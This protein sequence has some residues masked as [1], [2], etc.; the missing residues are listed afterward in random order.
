MVEA[1]KNAKKASSN[2][3]AHVKNAAEVAK[4]K[5]KTATGK[6]TGDKRVEVKGRLDQAKAKAKQA[7][8]RIKEA[9]ED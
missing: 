3:Q 5:V 1:R 4:G 8:Q 2:V 9:I 7:G 6:A